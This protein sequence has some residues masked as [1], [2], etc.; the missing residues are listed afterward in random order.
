MVNKTIVGFSDTLYQSLSTGNLKLPK[1]T[2]L[3]HSDFVL[4][5]IFIGN[6]AYPL[7]KWWNRTDKK[8]NLIADCYKTCW[9]MHFSNLCF[10]AVD[11][12]QSHW[13]SCRYKC[14]NC[15]MH[16]LLHNIMIDIE[17]LHE[18]LSMCQLGCRSRYCLCTAFPC[19]FCTAHEMLLHWLSTKSQLWQPFFWMI[20]PALF[21][22]AAHLSSQE[23]SLASSSY[24]S[25][26]F[27]SLPTSHDYA[28][29]LH[30]NTCVCPLK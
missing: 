12:G 5:H 1:D 4:P 27:P 23:A 19:L 10:R 3:P 9:G 16:C 15:D 8:Q 21:I 2:V 6:E 7:T 30:V 13:S 28:E 17:G 29:Q 14:E 22:A 26:Q 25:I 24:Q 20:S 18:S 11:S